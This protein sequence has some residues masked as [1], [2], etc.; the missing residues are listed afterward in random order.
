MSRSNHQTTPANTLVKPKWVTSEVLADLINRGLALKATYDATYRADPTRA[1]S[2]LMDG[3][4][5]AVGAYVD[6]VEEAK[7]RVLGAGVLNP[8]SFDSVLAP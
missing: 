7:C 4:A 5:A 1:D 6:D 2:D 8:G 3:L